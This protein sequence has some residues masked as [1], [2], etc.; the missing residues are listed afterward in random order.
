MKILTP[1]S[2]GAV[3]L[4]RT[5]GCGPQ[6]KKALED[7]SELASEKEE[8]AKRC[9]ELDTQVGPLHPGVNAVAP[10]SMWCISNP[11]VCNHHLC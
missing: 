9:L 11:L 5:C 8:L 4:M 2:P 10:F 6:L 3:S 1:G 7:L